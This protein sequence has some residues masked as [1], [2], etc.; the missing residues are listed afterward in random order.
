VPSYYKHS[1]KFTP[2]GVIG[3]LLAGAIAAV[4]LAFLYDYGITTIPSAKLRA[5]CTFAFGALIGVATGFGLYKGKVRNKQAAALVGAA[6]GSFG[7]Y[8]S[9]IVWI[10]HLQF[11]ARWLFNPAGVL[12][13][14]LHP[15]RVWHAAVII[16]GLG[17][18]SYGKGD[19]T[20]GTALWIVWALEALLILFCSAGIAAALLDHQ[21]FCERCMQWCG[22][23]Y[24]L[25]FAPTLAAPAFKSLLESG[26][27]S[28][29][30][31][32]TP[33]TTKQPHFRVDLQSC[34][35]CHTL[36]TLSLIQQ[37]PKDIKT[38]VRKLL[39][40]PEQ[41]TVIRD[42]EVSRRASAGATQVQ[43]IAK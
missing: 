13:I 23:R 32:L 41:A 33:G 30:A 34:A 14:A 12:R 1:G 20:K 21:P 24:K 19:P 8:I 11:P 31:K 28:E 18:W 4:P 22:E 25:V 43:A 16:N 10:L 17:T 36:N 37:F 40:T 6:I 42:L 39:V 3:G 9:W 35:A 7:L 27:V 26:N 15:Q 2:Q 38:V 29:L 5:I